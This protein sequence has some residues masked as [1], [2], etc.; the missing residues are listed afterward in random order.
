MCSVSVDYCSYEV[1]A[2]LDICNKLIC[3]STLGN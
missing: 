1:G 2:K 3:I